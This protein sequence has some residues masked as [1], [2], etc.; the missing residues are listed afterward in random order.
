MSNYSGN[1][2]EEDP[3]STWYKVVQLVPNN[4]RVLDVGCSSGNLGAYLTKNKNCEVIGIDLDKKDVNAAAKKLKAAYVKNVETDDLES[5]G[6]FDCIIFA[7]VIEH[8]LDPVKALQKIKSMLGPSGCIVFSIPN[9]AHMATRLMLLE[10]RFVYGQTGLLDRTHLH[11]YDRREIERVFKDSGYNV[12]VF[13]W[14]ERY[15]PE[16]VVRHQLKNMGLVP[17]A[18]FF[19]KNQE[20]ES[21][22]YQF[23][24]KA[25]PSSSKKVSITPIPFISP[26]VKPIEK[27]LKDAQIISE[28]RILDEREEL[29]KKVEELRQLEASIISSISWRITLPLRLV[30]GFVW[31]IKHKFRIFVH[32]ASRSP[33]FHP[34]KYGELRES[35]RLYRKE[36]SALS[37]I[38]RDKKTKTAVVIHLYYTDSWPLIKKRLDILEKKDLPFDVFVSMPPHNKE[39]IA[40]IK[41]DYPG[42]YVLVVP[43]RGRD[44]LPFLRIA[45]KL[46]SAGYESILKLHSKKSP[47]RDDGQKWFN[48]MLRDLIPSD[49]FTF[50]S[51]ISALNDKRSGVIGPAGQY[52]PL[53]INYDA[54]SYFLFRIL[55]RTY[56]KRVARQIHKHHQKYGFFA[57]TMFWVRTDALTK[58]LEQDFSA[59]D[60]ERELKRIDGTLA[61]AMERAF[62]LIPELEERRMYEIGPDSMTQLAY[63]SSNIPK[64]SDLYIKKKRRFGKKRKVTDE[65]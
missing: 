60:F 53:A 16:E 23:I 57:G 25:T 39:F 45:P 10:G 46:H 48:S 1:D 13:D 28:L 18:A 36:E 8:L 56:S 64:W 61:H 4:S 24:G 40:D 27:Q 6:T 11:Y 38:K 50:A 44:V 17:K 15:L 5:L 47:H 14:T 33:R 32:G 59:R 51:L 54:N 21:T 37:S 31:S 34:S 42:A 65:A 63:R 41:K 2:Y 35:I 9:I 19:R 20:V 62:C 55:K 52:V 29:E 43:N 12:D 58:I 26:N 7:D 30:N 3:N 22:A 49:P